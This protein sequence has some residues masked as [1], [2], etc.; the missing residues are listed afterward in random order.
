MIECRPPRGGRPSLPLHELSEEPSKNVSE[1]HWSW[2]EKLSRTDRGPPSTEDLDGGEK[3][4]VAMKS[5]Y[6]DPV[7]SQGGRIQTP[8]QLS[9]L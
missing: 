3:V 1:Y 7:I 6:V 5:M 4:S 9:G 2:K 8:C